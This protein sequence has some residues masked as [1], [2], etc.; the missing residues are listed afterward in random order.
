[1]YFISYPLF[2]NLSPSLFSFQSINFPFLPPLHFHLLL[3]ATD[4]IPHLNNQNNINQSLL[5]Q[6]NHPSLK[7]NLIIQTQSFPTARH[8]SSSS[9]SQCLSSQP[10]NSF[11]APLN[12]LLCTFHFSISSTNYYTC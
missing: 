1:M 8:H 7:H 6:P 11:T 4:S 3:L 2:S 10:S 12:S 5:S 9:F